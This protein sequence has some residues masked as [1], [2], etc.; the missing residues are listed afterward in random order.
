ME[1]NH[2][3]VCIR[4]SEHWQYAYGNHETEDSTQNKVRNDIYHCLPIAN[5]I[6][7]KILSLV[8]CTL[9]QLLRPLYGRL[10]GI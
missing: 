2:A 7:M 10:V 3:G 1:N 9:P 5:I 8:R 4:H 6:I